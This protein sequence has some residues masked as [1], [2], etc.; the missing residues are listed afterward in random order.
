MPPKLYWVP[1]ISPTSVL[2]YT[3][4][5]FPQWKGSALIGS[6]SG[7]AL[8]RVIINGDQARKAEQWDV[9]MHIRFVGQGPDGTIY[10]LEDGSDGRMLR[11][12]PKRS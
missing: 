4:N 12:T 6:L 2:F 7:Q 8:V 1:S 9:G 11:L 10:L 5:L 3:G